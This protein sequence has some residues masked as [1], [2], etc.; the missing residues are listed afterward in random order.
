MPQAPQVQQE[1]KESQDHEEKGARQDS[2]EKKECQERMELEWQGRR[3]LLVLKVPTDHQVPEVL[4]C[5][6]YIMGLFCETLTPFFPIFRYQVSSLFAIYSSIDKLMLDQAIYPSRHLSAWQYDDI[7]GITY[8]L[9]SPWIGKC[10]FDPLL[11]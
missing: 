4:Y 8:L 9:F 10:K 6:I 11:K 3:D 5:F 1:L 7:V 2:K